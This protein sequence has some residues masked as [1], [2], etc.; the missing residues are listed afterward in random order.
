MQQNMYY[1]K[2]YLLQGHFH[3]SMKISQGQYSHK[4]LLS[5]FIRLVVVWLSCSTLVSINIVTLRWAR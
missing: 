1:A 5:E 4:I 3:Y 2:Y